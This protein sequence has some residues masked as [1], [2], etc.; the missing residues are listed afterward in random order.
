MAPDDPGHRRSPR[1]TTDRRPT[2]PNPTTHSTP[3]IQPL[4]PYPYGDQ[5]MFA[6]SF[7]TLV[8]ATLIGATAL[9]ALATGGH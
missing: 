3:A 1:D 9:P 4:R 8:L 5:T 2:P 7:K 6:K